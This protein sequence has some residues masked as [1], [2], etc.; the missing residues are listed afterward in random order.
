M[1]DLF[2]HSSVYSRPIKS[3]SSARVV[4]GE[5]AEILVCERFGATRLHT[6]QG[7]FCPDIQLPCGT[8]AEVKSSRDGKIVVY[9]FRL[10]KELFYC[11]PEFPYFI[12]IHRQRC[13]DFPSFFATAEVVRTTLGAVLQACEGKPLKMIRKEKQSGYNRGGYVEGYYT[14]HVRDFARAPLSTGDKQ[15]TNQL[16]E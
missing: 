2:P 8:Y 16:N 11:G 12:V 5:M 14:I 3:P 6:G 15:Q 10:Q 9:K 7:E 13:V 4:Y 1:T